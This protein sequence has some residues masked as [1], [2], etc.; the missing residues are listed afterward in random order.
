M[1]A[2]SISETSV[3]FYQSTRCNISKDSNLHTEIL[4]SVASLILFVSVLLRWWN[5]FRWFIAYSYVRARHEDGF[6]R[7]CSKQSAYKCNYE[8]YIK[9]LNCCVS[10]NLMQ[11]TNISYEVMDKVKYRHDT[12]RISIELMRLTYASLWMPF[13]KVS[14]SPFCEN[15]KR[16]YS[17]KVRTCATANGNFRINVMNIVLKLLISLS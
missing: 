17:P 12:Q 5:I 4:I 9:E 8:C 6:F 1:E 3:N 16:I 13:C 10:G 7:E 15:V 14:G 2:V 11:Y